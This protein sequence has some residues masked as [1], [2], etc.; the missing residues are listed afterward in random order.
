VPQRFKP[1]ARAEQPPAATITRHPSRRVAL[2]PRSPD[3]ASLAT[4]VSR[5]GAERRPAVRFGGSRPQRLSGSAA[6]AFGLAAP[7]LAPSLGLSPRPMKMLPQQSPGSPCT[8]PPRGPNRG[9]PQHSGSRFSTAAST[10][11]VSE[12]PK[13]RPCPGLPAL[14]AWEPFFFLLSV[15]V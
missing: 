10:T 2:A 14:A 1:R 12:Q 9:A 5:S 7:D 8:P 11:D 15:S 4:P 6:P 13:V 3:S